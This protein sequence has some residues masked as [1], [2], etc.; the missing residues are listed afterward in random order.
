MD[1]EAELK[2]AQDIEQRIETLKKERTSIY[3]QVTRET[4]WLKQG[5]IIVIEE[6]R[7]SGFLGKVKTFARYFVI[8]DIRAH[9]WDTFKHDSATICVWWISPKS[10]LVDHHGGASLMHCDHNRIKRLGHTDDMTVERIDLAS[11]QQKNMTKQVANTN[12]GL[13]WTRHTTVGVRRFPIDF[14]HYR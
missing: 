14:T 11:L 13:F 8:R 3:D 5:D 9:D 2:R 6:K 12:P 1:I 10:G 7:R 4:F